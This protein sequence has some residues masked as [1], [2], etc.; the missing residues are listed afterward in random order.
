[1]KETIEILGKLIKDYR[2]LKDLYADACTV[3]A[4]QYIKGQMKMCVETIAF[5]KNI[6]YCQANEILNK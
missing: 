2:V 3:E 1:M 5:I 4:R 6:S